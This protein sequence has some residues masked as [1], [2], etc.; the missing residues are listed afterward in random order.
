MSPIDTRQL[1]DKAKSRHKRMECRFAVGAS[2]AISVVPKSGSRCPPTHS[3]ALALHSTVGSDLLLAKFLSLYKNREGKILSFPTSTSTLALSSNESG[4][5]AP[6]CRCSSHCFCSAALKKSFSSAE[7][8]CHG[9]SF[10]NAFSKASGLPIRLVKKLELASH[11]L[12]H[13][14][15]VHQVHASGGAFWLTPGHR[16]RAWTAWQGLS[17][18]CSF[19]ISSAGTPGLWWWLIV[20]HRL[21]QKRF[22]AHIL[23][24]LHIT[25]SH[26]V[27]CL[28]EV[29]IQG[30]LHLMERCFDPQRLADFFMFCHAKMFTCRQKTTTTTSH[31][32]VRTFWA[33]HSGRAKPLGRHSC[34]RGRHRP[35]RPAWTPWVAPEVDEPRLSAL[36]L[37]SGLGRRPCALPLWES[38]CAPSSHPQWCCWARSIVQRH[39]QDLGPVFRCFQKPI[40]LA[41]NQTG[42][43]TCCGLHW[44]QPLH[45]TSLCRWRYTPGK[46]DPTHLSM[47]HCIVPPPHSASVPDPRHSSCRCC[48]R[49]WSP[50][51]CPGMMC[52]SRGQSWQVPLPKLPNACRRLRRP[53]EHAD[54]QWVWLYLVGRCHIHHVECQVALGLHRIDVDDIQGHRLIEV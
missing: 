33:D 11:S 51:S 17:S 16:P 40:A 35:C 3:L 34:S 1:H 24:H 23:V 21:I 2:T 44:P 15:E 29:S 38:V 50:R 37:Q 8:I 13:H 54:F 18:M 48:R 53:H 39:L 14:R 30:F 4:R 19:D 49:R 10:S 46:H 41:R 26:V 6:Y 20:H 42:F 22:E 47:L 12:T 9:I 31:P 25:H 36:H 7:I 32:V 5:T 52:L 28:L 45:Q 27:D 43:S